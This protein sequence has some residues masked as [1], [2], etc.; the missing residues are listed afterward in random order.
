MILNKAAQT[1]PLCVYISSYCSTTHSLS[2]VE[3]RHG[4][5]AQSL[6]AAPLLPLVLGSC[7]RRQAAGVQRHCQLGLPG[8]L[9]DLHR[10]THPVGEP[11]QPVRS[12]RA[13]QVSCVKPTSGPTP[14]GGTGIC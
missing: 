13:E 11:W 5:P 9:V 8:Q 10:E 1:Q 12:C 3:E 2:E 7:G 14:P 6:N 4:D